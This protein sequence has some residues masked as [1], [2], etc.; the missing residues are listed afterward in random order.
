MMSIRRMTPN[1]TATLL[2]SWRTLAATILVLAG[3][4]TASAK[5]VEVLRSEQFTLRSK[6]GGKEY[7]IF[8]GRPA[9]EAPPTGFPVVYVLDGNAIF[10]SWLETARMMEKALG[11]VVIVGIGYP[12]DQP[13]DQPRRYLDYTPVTPPE[14]VRRSSNE[15][16]PKPGGTGGQDEFFRFIE[17]EVKP[18]V[19]RKVSIDRSR[20]ALF[21][22]SLAGLFVLHVLF[23]QPQSFQ[24]YLPASPSIWW[25]DGSIVNDERAF[26]AAARQQTL[27]VRVLLQVGELEQKLAPGTPPERAEFLRQARMVDNARELADRLGALTAQG[28]QVMF[29]VYEGE[30]HGSVVPTEISRGLRFVLPPTPSK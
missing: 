15:P 11:P 1:R 17:R 8:V 29:K 3:A 30:N 6:T 5:P 13:F 25:N 2:R 28:V 12:T 22:H 26:T 20:Q 4:S 21:G 23:T 27:K 14:R 10:G 18:T 9:A 16:P 24:T 19:E 7:R